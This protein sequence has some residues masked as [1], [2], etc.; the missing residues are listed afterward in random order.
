VA[1]CGAVTP[2]LRTLGSGRRV[3]C[4]VAGADAP[5]A[6]AQPAAAG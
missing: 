4:H 1:E 3:A 5:A 2:A 6:A